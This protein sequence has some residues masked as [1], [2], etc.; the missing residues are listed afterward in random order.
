MLINCS[1]FIALLFFGE[2]GAEIDGLWCYNGL[3]LNKVVVK[4]LRLN[5]D[6]TI[7]TGS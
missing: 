6:D 4:G 2:T 7:G 1:T 5:F 3:G